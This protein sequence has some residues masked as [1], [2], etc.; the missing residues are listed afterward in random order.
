MWAKLQEGQK[1][2]HR[3]SYE[4]GQ[5]RGG[6]GARP[7]YDAYV[8]LSVFQQLQKAMRFLSSCLTLSQAQRE[9][10]RTQDHRWLWSNLHP[11]W[12]GLSTK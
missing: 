6:R 5:I 2:R 3:V 4:L 9:P 1:D 12:S 11:T 7:N 8:F 10:L